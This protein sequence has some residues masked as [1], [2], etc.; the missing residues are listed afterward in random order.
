[1]HT[2]YASAVKES[3]HFEV[4]NPPTRSPDAL[5][6]QKKLTTFLVVALNRQAGKTPA[7]CFTVKIKQIKRS[8]MVSEAKQQ[9]GRS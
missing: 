4:R 3:G 1:V 8:G 9:A 2:A 5:F 6:P 7:D